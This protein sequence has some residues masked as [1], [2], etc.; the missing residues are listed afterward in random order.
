M[1]ARKSAADKAL[2]AVLRRDA[3]REEANALADARPK[4]NR[5][6]RLDAWERESAALGRKLERAEQEARRLNKRARISEPGAPRRA[7]TRKRTPTKK[8]APSHPPERG[9]RSPEWELGFNYESGRRTSRVMVNAR[10]RTRDGSAIS[11][12]EAEKVWRLIHE[13]AQPDRFPENIELD[14]I[15]WERPKWAGSVRTG[16][17]DDLYNFRN[18]TASVPLSQMRVKIPD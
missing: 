7:P 6:G 8:R 11:R 5:G 14:F 13:G 12:A 10:I 2:G 16:D 17:A 3:L 1:A 15:D 4:N 18:I 9:E